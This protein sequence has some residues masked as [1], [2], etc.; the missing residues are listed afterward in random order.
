[1]TTITIEIEILILI[2]GWILGHLVLWGILSK[3]LMRAS[4][5]GSMLL[6]GM[7]YA[8]KPAT[9]DLWSYSFFF[10][11]G[12]QMIYHGAEKQS[13]TEPSPAGYSISEV[14]PDYRSGVP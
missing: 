7:V 13:R 6:L 1:M 2:I 3:Q 12:Y 10:D 11:T 8:L 9:G 4:I 5:I 14:A